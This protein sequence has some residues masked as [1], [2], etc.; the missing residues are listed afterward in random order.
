MSAMRLEV[1]QARASQEHGR[2]AVVEAVAA[3]ETAAAAAAMTMAAKRSFRA[4]STRDLITRGRARDL[5]Q[6]RTTRIRRHSRRRRRRRHRICSSSLRK[7]K[8]SER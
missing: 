3:V 1:E 5:T 8:A 6:I 2:K 4:R 7:V